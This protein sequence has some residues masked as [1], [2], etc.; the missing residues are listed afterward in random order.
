[1]ANVG[2]VKISGLDQ[3]QKRLQELPE[4]IR[5]K[6][7][8]KALKDGSELV[9]AEAAMRAP[10]RKPGRGWMG[11]VERDDGPHLR[12]NITS[13]VTVGQKDASARVGIDYKKVHHGHLVEFGTKPHRIGKLHHPGS[14]K[15]PFMRPAWDAKGD[16]SVDTIITQLAQAIEKEV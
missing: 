2:S 1:M 7:I 13:R 15:Q 14:R 9:R 4:K 6:H 12:D 5:K 8:R 16:E 3:I 10:R 11:F